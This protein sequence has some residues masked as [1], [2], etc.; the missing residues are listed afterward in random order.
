MALPEGWPHIDKLQGKQ[1]WD[2]TNT[3]EPSVQ[4]ATS[5]MELL[6]TIIDEWHHE[7]QG[8]PS[9]RHPAAKKPLQKES[10]TPGKCGKIHMKLAIICLWLK[11][12]WGR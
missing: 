3:I 5:H 11:N 8:K 12:V 9:N 10:T 4:K 6:Q 1:S 7:R 2:Y